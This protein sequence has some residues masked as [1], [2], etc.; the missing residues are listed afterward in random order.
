[1]GDLN[2]VEIGYKIMLIFVPFLF[3][4]CFHEWAHG[5]VAKM[6]GD[7]TAELQ[8]RL[9]LNPM[10]HAD[11]IGTWLLPML[12]ILFSKGFFFGWAKPVP[13]DT[14]NLKGRMDMFW[15]AAAGP[16]SNVF[17]AF[18][19]AIV[20]GFVAAWVHTPSRGLLMELV[21]AFVATNLFLAVFNLIP[22]H[23]LD[24]G[25][26]IEP[27]L[28]TQWNMWLMENQ[29]QLNMFL[30]LFIFIG[31]GILGI[32]VLMAKGVLLQLSSFIAQNL[33]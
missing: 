32:P 17:L 20:L 16:L 5:M 24:G 14:R 31:G 15:I 29:L 22:I 27:F 12:A 30:L 11:P 2:L 19:A 13:V 18:V 6:K 28:P 9:T 1:M 25:K 7:R 4:L 3:S 10:A 21:N 33:V 8:G 26:I 23:P